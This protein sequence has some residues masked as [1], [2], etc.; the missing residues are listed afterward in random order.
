MSYFHF[1]AISHLCEICFSTL[2]IFHVFHMFHYFR[3]SISHGKFH[4]FYISHPVH[5]VF[6]MLLPSSACINSLTSPTMLLW[7]IH[8]H[9]HKYLYQLSSTCEQKPIGKKQHLYERKSHRTK[10]A[11]FILQSVRQIRTQALNLSGKNVHLPIPPK[12]PSW[13]PLVKNN[14]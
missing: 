10:M 4:M 13:R 11:D 8:D 3:S 14:T 1:T 6:H 9:P 7:M 5:M 2:E 12:E